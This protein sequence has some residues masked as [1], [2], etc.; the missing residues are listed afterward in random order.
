MRAWDLPQNFTPLTEK[1]MQILWEICHTS[2]L[3]FPPEVK[4]RVMGPN[5]DGWCDFHRAFDHSTE[6]CWSLKT[7]IER[8]VQQGH[9]SRF[10]QHSSNEGREAILAEK[11]ERGRRSSR[12]GSEREKQVTADGFYLAPQHHSHHSRRG[13]IFPEEGASKRMHEVQAV[14]TGANQTPLRT[15]RGT[16]PVLT[17]DDRDLKHGV[18]SHD[19]PMVISMIV[20]KYI[21]EHVLVDQGSS[22]N[23]LYWSTFQKIKLSS[24]TNLRFQGPFTVLRA[25]EYRLKELLSWRLFLENAQGSRPSWFY[26]W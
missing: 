24:S 25:S 4:G 11:V 6:D 23:I 1:M 22:S 14:L 20:A 12:G 17:F 9:L 3:E 15:K 13:G 26:T 18:P 19:E 16:N 10:V 5:K 2:L 8:L 21:I 7:Q